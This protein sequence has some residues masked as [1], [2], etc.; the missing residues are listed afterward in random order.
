MRGMTE[1]ELVRISRIKLTFSEEVWPFSLKRRE[2]IDAHFFDRRTAN[3][4][5]WN[6][7]VLLLRSPSVV[8]DIF[9]GICF[10]VDYASFLAW[11]DWGFPDSSAKA[12]VA[13]GALRASDGAFLLGVMAEHTAGAGSIHFPAGMPDLNDVVAGTVDLDDSML[14]E[15]TEETG[16]ARED[17]ISDS[18]W[19]S[20]VSGPRIVHFKILQSGCDS[21]SLRE[22]ILAHLARDRQSELADIRIV[23]NS[24]DLN[25]RVAASTA[26]FL[27]YIWR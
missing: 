22:K 16:I 20:F 9:H 24:A 6:G 23:R 5:L 17:I 19:H 3:P 25:D 13:Q 8:A 12:C 1:P 21:V 2:Q 7:Q 26:A 15:L 4:A 11:R 10:P 18:S 14:R 27:K